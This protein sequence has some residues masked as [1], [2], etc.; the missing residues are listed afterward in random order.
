MRQQAEADVRARGL[1]DAAA[2][3]REHDGGDDEEDV[4]QVQAGPA[5]PQHDLEAAEQGLAAST[6]TLVQ[7]VVDAAGRG[8]AGVGAA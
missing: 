2:R 4:G 6:V 7:L 3:A 1:P 8:E 5:V